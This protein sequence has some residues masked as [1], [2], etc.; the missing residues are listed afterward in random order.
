MCR[1]RLQEAWWDAAGRTLAVV[2]Q[3][4]QQPFISLVAE[5]GMS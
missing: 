5:P 3:D 4:L 2:A 1:A